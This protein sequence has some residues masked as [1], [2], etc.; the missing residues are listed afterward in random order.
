MRQLRPDTGQEQQTPDEDKDS[1]GG[2]SL[3]ISTRR[4]YF[5]IDGESLLRED[6]TL[7]VSANGTARALC[8]YSREKY[9]GAYALPRTAQGVP[10]DGILSGFFPS[11][12][13]TILVLFDS[14]VYIEE[15]KTNYYVS[16]VYTQAE[17]AP[18]GW[19]E[20]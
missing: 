10:V 14:I 19:K 1:S 12:D 8:R 7:F 15:A 17:S 4:C 11:A 5:G 6:G 18:E 3:P 2:I 20:D 13:Y 16:A 9:D